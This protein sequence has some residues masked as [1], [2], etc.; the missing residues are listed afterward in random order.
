MIGPSATRH[1]MLTLVQM[2]HG[3]HAAAIAAKAAEASA[4]EVAAASASAAQTAHEQRQEHRQRHFHEVAKRGRSAGRGPGDVLNEPGGGLHRLG[5]RGLGRGLVG[6][7]CGRGRGSRLF[8]RQRNSS[9]EGGGRRG[10]WRGSQIFRSGR[11]QRRQI[12]RCSRRC[13]PRPFAGRRVEVV[14]RPSGRK[15]CLN[16]LVPAGLRP[17]RSRPTLSD[18]AR[19]VSGYVGWRKL[20]R[21][22]CRQRCGMAAQPFHSAFRRR[23]VHGEGEGRGLTA[24]RN[25]S[26]RPRRL[27][28]HFLQ[29]GA[30][31]G[32]RCRGRIAL[33][34]L[35]LLRRR[36]VLLRAA[37]GRCV[38][39][40]AACGARRIA[41]GLRC[42]RWRGHGRGLLRDRGCADAACPAAG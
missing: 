2:A 34:L 33:L 13:A 41:A 20:G 29:Q 8:G 21:G 25:G 22:A 35:V 3:V 28:R 1:R 39:L 24:C 16:V 26:G 38:R 10:G 9:W 23:W 17:G 37:A 15:G 31:L 11:R 36:L 27:A 6:R 5:R 42:G 4:V 12:G 40:R 19:A 7:G 32:D 18:V 14:R 30:Q